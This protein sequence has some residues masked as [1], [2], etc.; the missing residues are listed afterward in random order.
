M[1]TL[2]KNSLLCFLVFAFLSC[3]VLCFAR[4]GGGFG[5]GFHGNGAF[6]NGGFHGNGNFNNDGFHAN[7]NNYN[8]QGYRGYDYHDGL[9]N[10]GLYY[11]PGV[12]VGAPVVVDDDDSSCQSTQVC[13]NSGQ[14]WTQQQCD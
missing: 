14:C 2:L 4:G 9:Y 12:V 11:N 7:V 10:N 3:P 13:N 5:G 6:D 8:V 1:N